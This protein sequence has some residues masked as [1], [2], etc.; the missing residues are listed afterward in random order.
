M[1]PVL[2]ALMLQAMYGAVD[3]L[4]VGRFGTTAGIS[5][6]STGS[7][8]ITMITVIING[9]CV[10]LTVLIGQYL[11]Q[12]SHSRIS[13]LI[14]GGI[15]FFTL[16]AVLLMS[17]LLLFSRQI[18]GLLQAPEEAIGQTVLYLRICGA[19]IFFV[20]AYN[21]I[22]G[23]FRGLGD[24]RLPLLF[25]MIACI[26]NIIG[27]LILVAVFHMNAAGAA[28]A[29]VF[30][31][32]VSVV[33]SLIIIRRRELPFS[34]SRKDICFSEEV[35]RFLRAGAPMACTEC[36][37][38]ISFLATCA[39]INRLGLDASSGYGVGQKIMTF[40]MLIPSSILQSMASFVAQ[41]VGANEEQRA[42]SAL[43][44]SILFGVSIGTVVSCLVI[45]CGDFLA[46]FFTTD[47]AVIVRAAQYLRGAGLEAIFT[48]I[49]FSFYGYFNGHSRSEIAMICGIIQTFLVRLPI[50]Y[51]MSIQP[52]ASLAG[53]AFAT[54]VSSCVGILLCIFFYV[55]F[56]KSL[57]ND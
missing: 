25:V 36:F 10:G 5:G 22:S 33:L 38:Y 16:V 4:I 24:S 11:G 42:R 17:F 23:I 46:G 9:L 7:S 54:P 45:F 50:A 2:G 20:I 28:F 35:T 26:A 18:A 48:T 15:C 53:I 6:V 55:R 12:G 52:E 8:V 40:V 13:R 34:L 32:A 27:D 43:K 44:V 37:T 41:N 57:L 29:T 47:A 1:L 30:A 21:V 51:I 14:G 56:R 49:L 19:G 39:F 31:Q 3:L